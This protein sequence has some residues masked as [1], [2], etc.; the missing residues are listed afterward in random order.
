MPSAVPNQQTKATDGHWLKIQRIKNTGT[1]EWKAYHNRIIGSGDECNEEGQHHVDEERDKGVKVDL[2]EDPH[3][4]PT[5][6]H[7]S[8]RY[9]HVV[10]VY[11]REQAL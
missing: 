3:H 5:L 6:L 10:S 7:L 4:C 11:Q 1:P 2:A 9:K 8:K